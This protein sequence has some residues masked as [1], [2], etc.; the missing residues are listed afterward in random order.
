MDICNSSVTRTASTHKVIRMAKKDE[1]QSVTFLSSVC[2]SGDLGVQ[3]FS[4]ARILND[5]GFTK[6]IQANNRRI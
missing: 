2:P 1:T 4:V 6:Y 3:L 5:R